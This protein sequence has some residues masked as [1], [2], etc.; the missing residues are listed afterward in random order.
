MRRRAVVVLSVAALIA[1]APQLARAEDND[2]TLERLIGPPSVAGTSP[3][4]TT[5]VRSAYAGLASELGVLVAP[6]PLQPADSLG[7]SGFAPN[8]DYSITQINRDAD[9]WQKGARS[10]SGLFL[11]TVGVTVRK[12]IWLPFPSFELSVGGHKILG[13][14]MFTLEL[15]AKLALHE[16]FHGWAIPSIALRVAVAHLFGSPQIGLTVLE[17][18]VLVSKRF[19]IGGGLQLDPYLGAAAIISFASSQV[20]DTTPNVDAFRQGPNAPDENANIT[21]PDLDPLPRF[22]LH[23][24]MR[25]KASLF[26]FT[27]EA[28]YVLCN[29][30]GRNCQHDGSIEVVDRSLGQLQVNIAAGVVY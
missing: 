12:G 1:S 30:T 18:G 2:L 27:A 5:A 3:T 7:W 14:G 11:G 24:G 19:A 26:S 20:I 29:S 23:G 9:Y 22:R 25:L 28:A 21:L 15:A 10:V 8:V 4:I 6:R 17:A 16:G 13:S